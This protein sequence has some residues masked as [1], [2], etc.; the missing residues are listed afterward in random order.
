MT[1]AEQSGSPAAS[2]ADLSNPAFLSEIKSAVSRHNVDHKER[3]AEVEESKDSA[4]E[5][6]LYTRCQTTITVLCYWYHCSIG[7]FQH[8]SLI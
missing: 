2:P 5:V 1:T 6:E 8:T 7:A 3:D 4:G